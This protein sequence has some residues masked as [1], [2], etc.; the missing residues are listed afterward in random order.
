M[1][2]NSVGHLNTFPG[3]NSCLDKPQFLGKDLG[4]IYWRDTGISQQ[5]RRT[6]LTLQWK[7]S[8]GKFCQQVHSCGLWPPDAKSQLIRKDPDA[9]K[10]WRQEEKGT[11]EDEMVGWH[12]WLN[13]HEFEQAL[14][15]GEGQG[16]LV[17][18]SP[19]CHKELDTTGWLNNH[20]CGKKA[21]GIHKTVRTS[22]ERPE[23]WHNTQTAPYWPLPL[24]TRIPLLQRDCTML[25]AWIYKD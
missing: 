9:G 5:R 14:G 12:H 22:K 13:G 2:H 11:T 25:W 18:C 23:H 8:C 6:E 21:D 4:S 19:W 10:D 24:E 3:H 17:C 7:G 15:D 20:S 1:C 16:S